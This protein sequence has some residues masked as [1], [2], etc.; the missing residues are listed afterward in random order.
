M[1]CKLDTCT[2]MLPTIGHM[3]K[4]VW[5]KKYV[6]LYLLLYCVTT[7]NK[8][9]IKIQYILSNLHQQQVICVSTMLLHHKHGL[10][11]M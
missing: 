1:L 3:S 11:Y 9:C 10:I 2:E 5:P 8:L 4:I 6:W 7:Y